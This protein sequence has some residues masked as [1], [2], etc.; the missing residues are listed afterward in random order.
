MN[1]YCSNLKI[2]GSDNNRHGT[3]YSRS[4][5]AELPVELLLLLFPVW[6]KCTLVGETL[7]QLSSAQLSSAL[8]CLLHPLVEKSAPDNK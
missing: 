3:F 4:Q 1:E 7:S 2:I 8:L 5:I 6:N